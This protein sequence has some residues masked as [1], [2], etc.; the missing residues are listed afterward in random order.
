MTRHYLANGYYDVD[1]LTRVETGDDPAAWL[2]DHYRYCRCPHPI[3]IR[4]LHGYRK[5]P[6]C[7]AN[8]ATA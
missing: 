5:C 2:E 4:G 3:L 6:S 1:E 7:G 8:G